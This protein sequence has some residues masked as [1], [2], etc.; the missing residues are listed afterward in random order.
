MRRSHA[1]NCAQYLGDDIRWDIA[2]T[3]PSLRSVGQSYGRIKVRARD[4]PERENQRRQRSARGQRIGKQGNGCIAA[5]ELFAHD[6]GAN[7]RSKKERSSQGFCDETASGAATRRTAR[8]DS[9]LVRTDEG[10][11]ELAFHLSS[12]RVDIK[13]LTREEGPRIFDSVNPR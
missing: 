5:R 8:S 3:N 7:D 12:Q 6:A 2:P 9:R 4:W 13:A 1:D 10:A 11:D